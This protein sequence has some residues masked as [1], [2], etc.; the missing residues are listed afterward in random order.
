MNLPVTVT[1][2]GI[3]FRV[4]VMIILRVRMGPLHL[5]I[6][7]VNDPVWRH[8]RSQDWELDGSQITLTHPARHSEDPGFYPAIAGCQHRDRGP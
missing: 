2:V 6:G 4:A 7:I 5:R 8:I 3:Q 1:V